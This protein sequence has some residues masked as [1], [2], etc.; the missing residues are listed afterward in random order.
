MNEWKEWINEINKWM[1]DWMNEIN[2]WMN[3][4]NQ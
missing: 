1:N 4:W 3:E 2:K